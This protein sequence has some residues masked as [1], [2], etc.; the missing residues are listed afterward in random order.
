ML[1]DGMALLFR[2]FYATSYAGQFMRTSRGI[3]TNA[4]YGFT[5]H[6]FLARK[7]FRPDYIVCCWDMG[8]TTFRNELYPPYK[9]NRTDPPSELVPQF[10]LV[11]EVVQAFD[12]PNI[13]VRGYEA[14]D[15]I[16]TLA[17]K[18]GNQAETLIVTSD[19]DYLQL[20]DD[21]TKVVMLKKGYHNY[22]V[23]HPET[24]QSELGITP[25]QIIDLKALMG[26]SADNYPGVKGI[27]EKTALKLLKKYR[28]A[29]EVVARIDE[30]PNGIRTKI[31][32][33]VDLLY[34]SKKLARI[35]REAPVTFSI[36]AGQWQLKLEKI[37]GRLNELD[38]SHLLKLII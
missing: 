22:H 27:G 32:A 26:D 13:G 20:L 6:L 25:D 7:A 14:D 9:A 23:Y 16:G 38:F 30:L 4:I 18:I 33:N 28:S 24:L 8:G 21:T 11:K 3:P 15:C 5:K 31:A 12:I 35:D 34:L 2:G 19:H 29:E 10:S 1:I 37:T 36:P 17:A